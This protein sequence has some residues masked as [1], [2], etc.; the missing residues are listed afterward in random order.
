MVTP[1][2]LFPSLPLLLLLFQKLN[3]LYEHPAARRGVGRLPAVAA[4]LIRELAAAGSNH[5]SILLVPQQD[6]RL[7]RDFLNG[8]RHGTSVACL[9]F[10][11]FACR[12]CPRGRGSLRLAKSRWIT[13]TKCVGHRLSFL[14]SLRFSLRMLITCTYKVYTI[15]RTIN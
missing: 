2:L 3:V 10:C 5:Q 12:A 8:G 15:R 14:R 11:S 4:H 1:T 13:A 9:L 6:I 7:R